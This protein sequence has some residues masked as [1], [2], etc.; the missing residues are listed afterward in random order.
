MEFGFLFWLFLGGI[1]IAVLQDVKRQEVDNWLNLFLLIAGFVFVFYGAVLSGDY[2]IIFL[3]GFLLVVMFLIMNLFYYGRIFAGGDAKLLFAMTAFFI[4][5][6]FWES[7]INIGV[8]VLALLISGSVYG[9]GYSGILYFRNRGSVNKEIALQ[10]AGGRWQVAGGVS[11]FLMLLGFVDLL[12]LLIGFLL[13]LFFGLY[14]FAKGLENVS[15]IREVSGSELREGDWL[16]NDIV[17]Y[18]PQASGRRPQVVIRADWD[19][20][21]LEDIELLKGRK[22]VLIKHGLPFVPAFL[23]AFLGY[24]FLKDWF[25]GLLIN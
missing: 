3:A 4:G 6:T 7:M 10:V 15:M 18:R 8:F 23:I 21:S 12:F 22:K 19:G 20:L 24:A 9:L 11:L 1:I 5:V 2:D 16:V 14:V 17:V 25:I 13:I